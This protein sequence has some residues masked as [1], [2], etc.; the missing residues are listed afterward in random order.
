MRTWCFRVDLT[1]LSNQHS[2]IQWAE[3]TAER[4]KQREHGG[5]HQ[6]LKRR[7]HNHIIKMA[8]TGLEGD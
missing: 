2:I 5:T 7:Q 6:E 1:R 8:E 3:T 4:Q